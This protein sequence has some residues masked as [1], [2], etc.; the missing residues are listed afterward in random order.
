MT[1][2]HVVFII[3]SGHTPLYIRRFLMAMVLSADAAC[4]GQTSTLNLMPVLRNVTLD[5]G[6]MTLDD[7]APSSLK[8]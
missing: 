6:A 7:G 4:Y 3:F 8:R 1:V 2:L 5:T